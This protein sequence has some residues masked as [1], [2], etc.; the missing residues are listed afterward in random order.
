MWHVILKD[1]KVLLSDKKSMAILII[2]PII[3]ISILGNSLKDMFTDKIDTSKKEV[4]I[5]KNYN[6]SKETN[7]F[8]KFL[9][10]N[11]F[12]KDNNK[13]LV[14]KVKDFNIEEE[15]INN[16]IKNK[17]IK[18]VI[19]FRI[20]E[21][22]QAKKLLEK[23][24]ISGIIIFPK[25]FIFNMYANFFTPFRNN[26][27]VKVISHPDKLMSGKII[28]GI[29]KG[30][31]DKLA[32]IIIGKNVF[33]ETAFENNLG[34]SSFEK[35]DK[36]IN[37]ISDSFKDVSVSINSKSIN[38]KKALSSFQFYSVGMATMFIIY[39]VSQGGMLSLEEK[40]NLTYQRM[41]IAGMSRFNIL[42]GKFF[43]IFLLAIVQMSLI[44]GFTSILFKVDW[45]NMLHVM[46]VTL[47]LIFAV[48]GLG[49]LTSV[50]AFKWES[51]KMVN[52]FDTI[53]ANLM[54]ILGGSMFPLEAFPKFLQ[55]FRYL[56]LNGL[57]IEAYQNVMLGNSIEK[58]RTPLLL[59]ISIG[60]IFILIATFFAKKEERCSNA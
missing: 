55:S 37:E 10:E 58:I 33:L 41:V 39:T 48:A 5:V 15:I 17:D 40:R 16:F 2:M 51:D 21:E 30:F 46:M 28:E 49:T 57:G 35:L 44:I 54:A 32:T 9:E 59:L 6:I 42:M 53:V 19:K 31:T 18:K 45:G 11:G 36:V 8:I 56:T 24:K 20:L 14:S 26:M 60:T 47:S 38:G 1:L 27:E 4:A 7:D 3:L 50:L 34:S 22:E 23:E 43:T 52:A 13:E 12:V 29:T 25:N